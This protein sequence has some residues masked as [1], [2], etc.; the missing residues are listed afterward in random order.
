MNELLFLES[1]VFQKWVRKN[2]LGAAVARLRIALTENP[3]AGDVIP[4]SGGLRKIRMA[5][6]GRGKRGGFRVV[7]VLMVERTVAYLIRGYSK[8]EQEDMTADELAD[9]VRMAVEVRSIAE[10]HAR[11]ARAA[12]EEG[13]TDG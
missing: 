3:D 12:A 1:S 5:G 9:C 7:Y 8:S 2:H 13:T 11:E 10:R 4:G 6:A